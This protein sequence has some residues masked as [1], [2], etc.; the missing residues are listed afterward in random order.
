[1]TVPRSFLPSWLEAQRGLTYRKA[2][3]ARMRRFMSKSAIVARFA[4]ELEARGER[5]TH[6]KIRAM[7]RG[8]RRG[9]A[10][11][12]RAISRLLHYYR[13]RKREK[14]AN[15][16][17]VEVEDGGQTR[18]YKSL[19]EAANGEGC[20]PESVRGWA[21]TGAPNRRGQVWRFVDPAFERSKQRGR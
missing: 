17:R 10:T 14:Y 21:R 20:S 2:R 1:M 4:D 18:A 15:G 12:A 13:S 9:Y 6:S 7:L 11:D 3:N 8:L 16:H 5:V 19:N